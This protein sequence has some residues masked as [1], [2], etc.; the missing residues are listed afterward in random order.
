MRTEGE[1]IR[2]RTLGR[3]YTGEDLASVVVMARPT[4]EI[5]TLDRIAVINDGFAEDFVNNKVDGNRA[6]I[7]NIQH[8]G[9]GCTDHIPGCPGVSKCEEAAIATTPHNRDPF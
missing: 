9:R 2:L 7:L 4:G 6:V 1:E 8:S 5:I 3:K